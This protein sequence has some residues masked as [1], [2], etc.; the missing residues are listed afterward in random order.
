MNR[1]RIL[2]ADKQAL[3][4]AGM[5]SRLSREADFEVVGQASDAD[6]TI[7]LAGQFKPDVILLDCLLLGQSPANLVQQILA[8]CERARILLLAFKVSQE[9]TEGMLR[10]PVQRLILKD[11][12]LNMLI[13]A[14]RT[15]MEAGPPGSL[16]DD[17][18]QARPLKKAVRSKTFGLTRRELEIVAAIVSGRS[19]S[20]IGKKLGISQ[21]TVKHH[22]TSVFDKVGVYNRLELALFAIHHGLVGSAS[23]KP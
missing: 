16:A 21:D 15:T 14:I 9:E 3:F 5:S 13:H 8:I 10:L 11:S 20:A 23:R 18:S 2:I 22:L 1:T 17:S 19:N 12:T 4:R 7:C 6:E